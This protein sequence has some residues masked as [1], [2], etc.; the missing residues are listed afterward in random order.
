VSAW[1]AAVGLA[2]AWTAPAQAQQT[3]ARASSFAYNPAS[4]LLTQEVVEPDLT[5]FRLQTDYT[6]D[7]FGNRTGVTVSGGDIATRSS[8]TIFDTRGQFPL[9]ATNALN[10]SESWVYDERFGQP[11]SHTGPNGLT[12]TWQYDGFGRKTLEL[13]ADGT[14][15]TWSYRYCSGTAGGTDA[16]PTGAA[17]L[18]ETNVLGTDGTTPIAPKTIGYQDKLGRTIAADTQGFDGSTIRSL[19]EYDNLGRVKRKSRPFFLSGGT[20]VYQTTTYDILNR[21]TLEILPDNTTL[22]HAYSGLTTSNTNAAGQS[23]IE[24]KN[25]QGQI[26]SVTDAAGRTMTYGYDAFGSLVRAADPVGNITTNSYDRRGRKI[27]ENDPDKGPCSYTYDVLDQ[28]LTKTDAKGQLISFTYDLLGRA[29]QRIEPSLTSTWTYDTAVKG[30]GKLATA[31]TDGGYSR[32]HSYDALGRPSQTTLSIDGTNYGF[33]A[34]YDGA[35]RVSQVSYPS[36]LSVTYGYSALGY[37][38]QLK[39]TATN[40]VYWTANTRDAELRLTEQTAGNGV[41][42]SQFFDPLMG[43][44]TAI[45]SGVSAAVQKFDLHL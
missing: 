5:Q 25:S 12:T 35:G 6:I 7:A 41:A 44:L 38:T 24:I 14:R 22:Q 30:I 26:V 19:T 16:C 42:T 9:T 18:V 33:T 31:S 20:P 39:N 1:A 13:R 29:L 43:R 23:R 32:T 40:Q 2:L 3:G 15:T 34:S 21:P 36:G 8:T 10:Q 17:F 27:A 4:G 28:V 45:Q 11:T 37:Q